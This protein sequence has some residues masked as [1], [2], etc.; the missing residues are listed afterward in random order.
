MRKRKIEWRKRNIIASLIDEY[1]IESYEDTQD[2]LKDS[3]D[4]T[5]ENRFKVELDNHLCYG[6]YERNESSNSTNG[7]RSKMVR[8]KYYQLEIDVTQDCDEFLQPK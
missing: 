4:W 5:I 6:P 1:D 7:N 8:R 3:Q 2:T